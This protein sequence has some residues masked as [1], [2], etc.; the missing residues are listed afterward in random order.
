MS[1]S[2]CGGIYERW[3]N[4]R[5]YDGVAPRVNACKPA[6]EWQTVEAVFRAPRF[7]AA[8][9]KTENARFKRVELNHVL[10]HEDVEVTG[11]T[12]G[13]HY[14]DEQPYGPLIAQGDHGP[15]AFRNVRITPL[16]LP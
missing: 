10:I 6:G 13:S 9:R 3:A 16:H 1:S 12:R 11:P 15:V 2:D 14:E 7:D 8:G 4:D 5:G